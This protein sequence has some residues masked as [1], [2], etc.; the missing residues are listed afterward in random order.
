MKKILLLSGLIIGISGCS[1]PKETQLS[2]TPEPTIFSIPVTTNTPLM[3]KSRDLRTAQFVALIDTGRKDVRPIHATTNLRVALEEALSRQLKAQ[4]YLVNNDSTLTLRLDLLDAL[5][6]VKHSMLSNSM[7]AN[8]Q[9]QLVAQRESDKF[10]KR[11]MGKSTS[12]SAMSAS[13]KDIEQ[14]LNTLLEAVFNEMANDKQLTRFMTE[15]S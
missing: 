9:I 13:N 6:K 10:V 14:M 11:Y 15:N 1:A 3:L 8:V 4:G 12:K 7:S 5:V 2:I